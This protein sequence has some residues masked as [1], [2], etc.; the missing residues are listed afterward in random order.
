MFNL[1]IG[2]KAGQGMD[3][4][5]MFLEKILKRQGYYVFSNKDYMSRIRGGHNFMQIRFGTKGITSHHPKLDVIIAMD[6]NTVDLHLE[7][8]QEN[9]VII[10]DQSLKITD[11]RCI[12]VPM[13]EMANNIG[14]PRVSGSVAIGATLKLFGLALEKAEEI[15]AEKFAGK[16]KDD[17][18]E[19]IQQ[20]YQFTAKRYHIEKGSLD[21]SLLITSNQAIALGALAGGLGFYSGYPMT[22]ATSIM[23]Y[24]SQKQ[25]A[26][27]IVV[28]QV[29]DEIAAINMAIGASYAGVRAMTGTSGG[30]FSLMVEALGLAG[31]TETPLVVAN[32]QRPGPATGMPT[33]TEQGDLSFVLTASHGEFPR[34]VMAVRNPEDAFYQTARAL[35]LAEKY[36]IPVI[37]L[38]DQYLS[39][40]AETIE[41]FDFN[42]ISIE[43]CLA[44]EE[45]YQDGEYL[46]YHLTE[47]GRS[48][49]IIPGKH[50]GQIV[51]LDSDEHDQHGH[52]TESA[53][54]R[55]AMVEKRMKRMAEL[56]EEMVEPYFFG[57]EDPEILLLGWGSM[58]GPLEEAVELLAAAGK[59]VGAMV[60]GD[61][62]PLPTRLLTK[63]AG[64]VS[65]I[66]NVE[67][68]YTGQ[69]AKLIRQETGIACHQS[70][71]KY[72]GRQLSGYEIYQKVQEEVCK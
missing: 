40:A 13:R 16:T 31:M 51:L 29:E 2:G 64:R 46:P 47:S 60:F 50:Y 49:R 3:S 38:G 35:N 58:S 62:Y 1:L 9:G 44:G 18:L 61:I 5:S 72:D 11:A 34:M 63:Y 52:I 33:R 4:V 8:L 67:Q 36:R 42:K 65:T 59:A 54:V 21:R 41:P 43:R 48:L 6:R 28:E 12:Q 70:I 53:G 20:G 57:G 69:M 15:F 68:N 37:I 19:A 71:L 26:A 66:V 30:G 55:T 17:N 14:N 22:P 32:I 39:D 27:K 24:L 45:A 25:E 10:A 56:K 23:T 7:R